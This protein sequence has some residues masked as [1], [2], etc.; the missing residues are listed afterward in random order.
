MYNNIYNEFF[1]LIYKFSGS[2]VENDWFNWTKVSAAGSTAP[3]IPAQRYWTSSSVSMTTAQ[4]RYTQQRTVIGCWGEACQRSYLRH[5]GAERC[6]RFGLIRVIFSSACGFC[7]ST[8]SCGNG[9]IPETAGKVNRK[10][11]PA[12]LS[13]HISSSPSSHT[14]WIEMEM[15]QL[16]HAGNEKHSRRCMCSFTTSNTTETGDLQGSFTVQET[17]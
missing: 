8:A 3:R 12:R 14:Q 13:P 1:F 17:D 11:L 2:Q 15:L 16:L 9:K 4:Q 10:T 5:I 6:A 7:T